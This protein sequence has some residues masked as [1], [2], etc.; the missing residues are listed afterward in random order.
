MEVAAEYATLCTTHVLNAKYLLNALLRGPS[1]DKLFEIIFRHVRAGIDSYTG[2]GTGRALLVT[3]VMG[4]DGYQK[5]KQL[6][7]DHILKFLPNY[8]THLE[9][10]TDSVMDVENLLFDKMSVLPPEEFEALL[11]PIFEED[12]WKLVALGGVLGVMVG[13]LQA[14]AFQ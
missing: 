1:A 13:T 9:Q 14:F 5:S 10:Y 11:H 6:A 3:L 8:L 7:C 12:E 4:G 2:G